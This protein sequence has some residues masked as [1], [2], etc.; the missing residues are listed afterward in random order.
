MKKLICLTLVFVLI[1]TAFAGCGKK[2]GGDLNT[3]EGMQNPGNQ[4]RPGGQK[5]PIVGLE[6][7][8][9]LLAEERLHAEAL[10]EKKDIFDNGSA[11]MQN[12]AARAI[13][14]LSVTVPQSRLKTEVMTLESGYTFPIMRLEGEDYKDGSLGDEKQNI[15]KAEVVGDTVEW[16]EFGEVSNSYEYFLNLTNNIVVS[17]NIAAD[18]IAF[19]KK[20]IRI[21]DKWVK[22]GQD[23]YYLRVQENEELL[24]RYDEFNDIL[25]VCRRYRNEA[26]KDVYELYRKN[27]GHEERMTYIP[28]ERYELSMDNVYFTADFSKGYWETYVLGDMP[29]YYNISYM[30]M[31]DDICFEVAYDPVSGEHN[32]IKI[33]SADKRTDIVFISENEDTS[34]LMLQLCAFDG[35]V[36]VTAPKAD[37]GFGE[38]YIYVQNPENLKLHT[39]NGSIVT[40][41]RSADGNVRI[42]GVNVGSYAYGYSAELYLSVIGKNHEERLGYLKAYLAE[43][44]LVCRRDIDTVFNGIQRAYVEIEGLIQFYKWNGF[45]VTTE[46]NIRA[47]LEAE[48]ARFT[49]MENYYITLKS[50]EVIEFDRFTESEYELLVNF[51]PVTASDVRNA[52]VDGISISVEHISLT[53][54]DTTLIVKDEPYRVVLALAAANGSLVH[55]GQEGESASLYGG[56]GS[57][58]ASASNIR[59]TLPVLGAGE[60]RVVAYIATA[61]GIRSSGYIPV[62][63]TSSQPLTAIRADDMMITATAS[64]QGLTVT[65]TEQVD[66][67]LEISSAETLDYTAFAEL[68]REEAFRYGM[69]DLTL[70]EVRN[71]DSYTALTGTETA[72]ADGTYRL[73]YSLENGESKQNGYIYVRFSQ[74]GEAAA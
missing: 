49:E 38:D 6:A 44:G 33:I 17:A 4:D 48:K 12:L 19:T 22:M 29:T 64:G 21:V 26:G 52:V 2:P 11:V 25:D 9:L 16:S 39:A 1:L 35:V 69:P 70:V 13:A 72:M 30:I 50:D 8:K 53:I 63:F 67:Y 51:A 65:Y 5:L 42:G 36:K 56:E 74:T 57:F 68:L 62:A 24:C 28:G 14:N 23:V 18:M 46:E 45:V 47:A 54:D 60:Y 61:D 7:A 41:G 27:G 43:I 73:S 31:K 58:T 3:D 20:N 34:D 15:G 37:A 55:V 10:G 40:T 71:G 59:L 66:V 32:F